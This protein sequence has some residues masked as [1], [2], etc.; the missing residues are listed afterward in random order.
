MVHAPVTSSIA[1]QINFEYYNPNNLTG[2]AV[3]LT[4]YD[5]SYVL[6]SVVLIGAFILSI[7]CHHASL[8]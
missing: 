8:L 1:L 3:E 7:D 6:V 4:N 2:G 5:N